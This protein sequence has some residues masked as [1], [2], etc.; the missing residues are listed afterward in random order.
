MK[1]DIASLQV[2]LL[3]SLVHRQLYLCQ[4]GSGAQRELWQDVLAANRIFIRSIY[5]KVFIEFIIIS[6]VY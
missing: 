1:L 5:L 3:G 6:Y 4:V 2:C